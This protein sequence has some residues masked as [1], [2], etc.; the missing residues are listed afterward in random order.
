MDI[1]S[2]A[3]TELYYLIGNLENNLKEKIP[4]DIMEQIAKEMN[5]SFIPDISNV[6]VEAKAMLSVIYSDYLCS[7][8]ENEKWKDL[9][10]L[11]SNSVKISQKSNIVV[12]ENENPNENTNSNN[13]TKETTDL[14]VVNNEGFLGKLLCKIKKLFNRIRRKH[15]YG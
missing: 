13:Q 6:S 9:D 1:S 3:Y 7:P 8:E 10:R 12:N 4:C 11:Y 15:W 2:N 14:V 5:K